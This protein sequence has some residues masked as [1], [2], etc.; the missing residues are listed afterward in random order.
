VLGFITKTEGIKIHRKNCKNIVN[1]F[2]HDPD[3]ILEINWNDSGGGDYTG[4]LKIIGEDRPGMLNDIT[5]V[6]A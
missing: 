4:G 2:L 1:L 3:R 6:N 5:N